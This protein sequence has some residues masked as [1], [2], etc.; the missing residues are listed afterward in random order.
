MGLH[1]RGEIGE[2]QKP[3]TNIA[4]RGAIPDEQAWGISNITPFIF[5]S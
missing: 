2:G 3:L 4:V 1:P 5:I